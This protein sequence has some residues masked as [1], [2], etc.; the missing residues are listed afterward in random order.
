VCISQHLRAT[1]PSTLF[2]L[3]TTD[4]LQKHRVEFLVGRLAAFKRGRASLN[5]VAT[6]VRSAIAQGISLDG[7]ALL[8]HQHDL[9]WNQEAGAIELD[10][11]GG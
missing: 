3:S 8:L 9:R 5:T 2:V 1:N 10:G 6:A 7:V 4:D 11:D